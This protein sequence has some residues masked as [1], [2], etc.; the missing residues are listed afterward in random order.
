MV[1]FILIMGA[2]VSS[3]VGYHSS[4]SKQS[5]IQTIDE[6]IKLP[7]NDVTDNVKTHTTR[8]AK[9]DVRVAKYE[10]KPNKAG[11]RG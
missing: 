3:I 8:K 2:L 7:V 6:V 11:V 5:D 10:P 4:K 9:V 1:L